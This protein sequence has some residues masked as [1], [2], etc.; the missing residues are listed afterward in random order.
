MGT[1]KS[2]KE[3]N[4]AFPVGARAY[5]ECGL[6]HS[7]QTAT[8]TTV[9]KESQ[10][11]ART[12]EYGTSSLTPQL[13]AAATT[14]NQLQAKEQAKDKRRSLCSSRLRSTNSKIFQVTLKT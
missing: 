8:T 1:Q 12:P 7:T 11:A 14:N 10:R 9:E 3:P 4:A 5:F 2:K 6:K 13:Q